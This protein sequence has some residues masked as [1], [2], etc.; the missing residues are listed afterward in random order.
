MLVAANLSLW[1]QLLR[2]GEQA[3][4]VPAHRLSCSMASGILVS[5]PRMEPESP[6]LQDGFLTLDHQEIPIFLCIESN[7]IHNNSKDIQT[8]SPIG[9]PIYKC[10]TVECTTYAKCD[11]SKPE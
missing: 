1:R 6:A 8:L 5:Q 7:N 9:C 3:S 4:I 10:N 2:R 11:A